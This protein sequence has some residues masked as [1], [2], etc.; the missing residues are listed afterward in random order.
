MAK[1]T[2]AFEFHLRE[3]LAAA[4]HASSDTKLRQLAVEERTQRFL[5]EYGAIPTRLNGYQV[6]GVLPIQHKTPREQPE[7]A[8]LVDRPEHVVHRYAV[9]VWRASFGD[10]WDCGHYLERLDDALVALVARAKVPTPEP[11]R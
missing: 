1:L 2:P 4:V 10:S 3:L 6:I 11:E 7:Y 8:V 5:A 9:A